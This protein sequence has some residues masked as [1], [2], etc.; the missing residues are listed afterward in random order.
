[1]LIYYGIHQQFFGNYYRLLSKR[2]PF[3]VYY[4]VEKQ[5]IIVYAV[6]DCRRSPAWLAGRLE[7]E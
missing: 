4:V 2:F 6:L 3:A 7:K 5:G 1:M